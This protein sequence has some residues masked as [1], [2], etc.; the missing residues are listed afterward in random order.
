MGDDTSIEW[1]HIA[2]PDGRVYR[3]A[4]AIMEAFR[5]NERHRLCAVCGQPFAL[6]VFGADGQWRC[7]HHHAL[8]KQQTLE[9]GATQLSLLADEPRPHEANPAA[10][11]AFNSPARG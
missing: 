8:M 11:A 7:E 2:L 4:C 3:G 9:A 6:M 10:R 5:E 1:T